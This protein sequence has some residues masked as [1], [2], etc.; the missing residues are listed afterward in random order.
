MSPCR[1]FHN[2]AA[3]PLSGK[4]MQTIESVATVGLFGGTLPG[5]Y[6]WED[7]T[8]VLHSCEERAT[9]CL[10]ILLELD[11]FA[12]NFYKAERGVYPPSLYCGILHRKSARKLSQAGRLPR[13]ATYTSRQNAQDKSRTAMPAGKQIF[14]V[15]KGDRGHFFISP[16]FAKV[17]NSPRI[18]RW[19]V[20]FC[21]PNDRLLQE[22]FYIV[23]A[24]TKIIMISRSDEVWRN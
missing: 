24:V 13:F 1:L 21:A 7:L 4:P 16:F 8:H 3:G 20:F 6:G 19:M 9:V 12:T 2:Q 15:K 5:M 11:A 17:S 18:W 14:C 10:F 22:G 23:Y